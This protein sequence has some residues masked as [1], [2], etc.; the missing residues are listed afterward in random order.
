MCV[1]M[2]GNHTCRQLQIAECA[3][4]APD[5]CRRAV[6]VPRSLPAKCGLGRGINVIEGIPM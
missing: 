6:Y 4:L 5:A 2:S 3:W 1:Y